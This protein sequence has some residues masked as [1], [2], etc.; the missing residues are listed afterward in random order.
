MPQPAELKE[1]AT[2]PLLPLRDVVVF[3]HMV[4]PLFVGRAK[5]IR[6]LELAMD[7]GKQILLVAQRSAS[8]DEPS[9]DD[10]Y[11]VGTIASVLQMLK[12]PDGTVKVLVEGRQRAMIESV[13]EENECF[14]GAFKPLSPEA[15]ESTET[16]A[17]RRA[18]LAQFE[19]Y[20]KLNK[21][22]PPEVLNS[23]A[24]IDRAGRMADTI[25]AHLPLKLEQ[26]QEVLEMFD[27]QQR[28]E[29]LMSQ[30]EGEIDILQV[31]KRI[32][33]RVKRQMEKSQREYYLNEQVKAI[34]KELGEMDE[35]SDLD[36]LENKIKVAGMSKEG[37]EKAMSELKKLRMMS[38]MSAEATVVR[39]YIDTLLELPWKKKTKISKDVAKAE[40]VLDEDHFGLEKVKERIL[41]YLAV[42]QRVDKLKAPILCLVGP[43]GVG[44]TSLGQSL[45]RATN[46]KF[47]RMA[48]GGVRDESEIRGHRRT[49]IGSMPGKVLQNMSKA[50]V[51][52]PLFLLDE[53]DKM[54]ADFRGD[55]SS[56][57]LE[58]LDPEQNHSF[59]DHYAEVEFDLS[60]VM[61]VAT[62]NSLNIPPALLDRMEIIRLAGYT[63]DE[64]VNIAIKYLL[65]KQMKA[66]GVQEGELAVQESALRDIVRYYTREAGVRSLD[67]EIAKICRKVVTSASLKAGKAAKVTV[68][69]RNLDKYLGVRRFDYGIAEDENRIGQVTGLAWTEVGGELL[70]IEAVSLP[71]KG[72]IIR[73]GQLGEVMQESI[74]AAM[75]VVRSRARSL[76]IK[77]DFYEKSDM[78]IHVPEG[79][80]PKDGPS[81]GIAMTT[82]LV[83]ILTG[84]PVR[85]DVA[86]TGEITL[87]GEVLPI[88]GLKEKL[89][90]AHRGGIKHVLIPKGNEKDLVEI[91]AN[92]K[93]KI[94]IHAVKWIDEVLALALE[95]QPE[96]LSEEEKPVE[97]LRA[98]QE[99]GQGVSVMKH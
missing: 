93:H 48:L 24:G 72:N 55:P 14:V 68:S 20:V 26:K 42:Q 97:E 38:P 64:K 7:E 49:Y 9:A 56:A 34:Q 73:T 83:S 32:R 33:G 37:R 22:I 23:L 67:R 39:N 29:H 54:G 60:D 76:G 82:A 86:M 18:L 57:L 25:I 63:E 91:P 6:A 44:K 65:P 45:A 78:H 19:Q 31:E 2:L 5:S 80:T 96:P 40:E 13:G 21:K 53:V 36:E 79:A 85:A 30:L 71:G 51:K 47:V 92:I 98:T 84:I 77:P 1:E 8:K 58:V 46:R 50:A 59:I 81:A 94:E 11:P 27:V 43:P 41:E 89:L 90:A 3:P 88:G 4:I 17:M 12:L 61:F 52:N 99:A 95:R 75:S 10:L 16:E 69:G 66:N 15:E 62:A 70:T 87:R 35:V 74:T 28:L